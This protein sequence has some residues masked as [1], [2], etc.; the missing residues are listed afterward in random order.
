[1]MRLVVLGGVC[2]VMLGSLVS[3]ALAKTQKLAPEANGQISFVMPS[4][5]VDCIYTPKGGTPTYL[6]TGGGPELSCDRAE[7]AY[8][9]VRLAPG[10]AAVV[11]PDPG[12]QPCCSGTNTFAYGNTTTLGTAFTCAS[13]KAGLVCETA[14][15][16]HGFSISRAKILSH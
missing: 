6:P 15:K 9:N 10:K 13:D 2:A 7:P 11:T 5:N 14:D 8:V 4:S 12:E 1:M 16:H 3:P